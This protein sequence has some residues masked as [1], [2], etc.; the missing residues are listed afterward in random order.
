MSS[1]DIKP[2]VRLGQTAESLRRRKILTA[3]ALLAAAG[4]G[5]YY[6]QQSNPTK[7]EVPVAKV[8]RGEFVIA[9]KTRGDVRSTRS[10]TISVPQIPD[11]RIV[12]LAENGKTIRKGEVIVEFDAAQQEQFYLD[13]ATSV[14]TVDKEIVQ[15]KAS[16][17][18]TNEM[19][20][21]N[22]MT[23]GYNV[24]RAKLEASKAEILSEIEGRKNR[25]DV[26]TA[27]GDL[28]Q[29]KTTLR[30]RK[31]TQEADMERLSQ[32]KEKT[33]R[34]ASRAQSYL[35]KMSITAPNDGIVNVLPNYRTQGSF[36]SSPPPFKEGDRA[37]TGAAIA[38]IPDLSAMRVEL[39]LD[40]VD[41]GKLQL[42]QKLRVRVDAIPEVEFEAELDWISPIAAILWKGMGLTE[43]TFPARA[44]LSKVD[45]R[46]RPGMSSTAEIIIESEKEATLI[47]ARASFL[48]K[49]KPA[50]WIQRGERFEIR[51]IEVGKRNDS[52][53]VVVSGLKPGDTIAMEDPNEA[54]KR[55]KK[56]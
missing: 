47:P 33:V 7:V 54:A 15:L 34:D 31:T 4:G 8:R 29:V 12:R 27:E 28:D 50:V 10:V 16:H 26:T 17:R 39:K 46:L 44:T 37:W 32:K 24:E 2:K 6:Y 40:E 30:A 22:L 23:A 19:D 21:M 9:V 11:P 42:G 3:V 38:E 20:G 35:S 53:L 43:K 18:I 1:K 48:H 36:G 51:P 5:Y 25:I 52:D 41:R 14:R 45:P 49:G 13:R 55:A 56:L